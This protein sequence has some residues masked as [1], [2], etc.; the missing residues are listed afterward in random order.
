MKWVMVQLVLMYRATLAR[1]LGGQ[2]K[3][4]PSC[5]QYAIDAINKYGAFRGGWKAMKRIS[6]C[7]PFSHGGYDPA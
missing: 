4:Q 3:F 6:R 5:S 2:C 7:H 1:F